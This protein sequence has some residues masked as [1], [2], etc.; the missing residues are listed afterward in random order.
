MARM[1]GLEMALRIL[2]RAKRLAENGAITQEADGKYTVEGAMRYTIADDACDCPSYR[3]NR[4]MA[5][6][7][8]EGKRVAPYPGLVCKHVVA[9]QIQEGRYDFDGKLAVMS[10]KAKEVVRD[11]YRD[12][13]EQERRRAELA[14][15]AARLSA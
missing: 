13:R 9:V 5:Q 10:D 15:E 14:A 3:I 2:G 12:Q 1:T 11:G 8:A 7:E 4:E 6:A